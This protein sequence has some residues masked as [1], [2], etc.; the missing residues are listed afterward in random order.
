M[1]CGCGLT[2][3]RRAL[4][5][6]APAER[7]LT[8]NELTD[9][10]TAKPGVTEYNCARRTDPDLLIRLC[11]P[12]LVLDRSTNSKNPTVNWTHR[13][14][15]EFLQQSPEKVKDLPKELE[16]FFGNEKQKSVELGIACL[17]YLSYK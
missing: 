1:D 7:Q 8:I 15:M 11:S 3:V 2:K 13:T 16:S 12:L 6:V 9:A 17:T 4:A 14:A 5:F 10:L